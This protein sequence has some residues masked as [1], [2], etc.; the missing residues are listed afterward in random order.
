VRAAA[1]RTRP[2]PEASMFRVD[3]DVLDGS[4]LHGVRDRSGVCEC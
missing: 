3:A 1:T 2:Y 4:F